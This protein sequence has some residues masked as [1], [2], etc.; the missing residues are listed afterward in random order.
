MPPRPGP[1]RGRV[2]GVAE[3]P[4]Y[5]GIVT[6]P[7]D[8]DALSWAGDDDPTLVPGTDARVRPTADGDASAAGEHPAGESATAVQPEDEVAHADASAPLSNAALILLGVFGG[9]YLLYTIGWLV[10]G[11]RLQ[12]VAV[13]LVAPTVS[14]PALVLAVAAPF[15][16]FVAT[17]LLTRGRA[18]WLRLVWLAA[19][20]VLLVPWPFAMLG[21]GL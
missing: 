13:F 5:A 18:A 7:S 16:W 8:D 1:H 10:G 9:V 19:G 6:R 11:L 4:R 21:S 20:A 17:Y 15:V 14:I 3:R 2:F 12:T